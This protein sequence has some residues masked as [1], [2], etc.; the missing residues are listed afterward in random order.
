[1]RDTAQQRWFDAGE[2]QGF[3]IPNGSTEM[4]FFADDLGP[5]ELQ[6]QKVSHFLD[7]GQ[8]CKQHTMNETVHELNSG[9]TRLV[10]FRMLPP[11]AALDKAYVI[12]VYND[13]LVY[14]VQ[15]LCNDND[16]LYEVWPPMRLL[17]RPAPDCNESCANCSTTTTD[18]CNGTYANPLYRG[19]PS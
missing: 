13:T 18:T 9:T 10:N 8:H 14:I 5:D 19:N 12:R 17:Q 6:C 7:C 15:G 11:G 1:M 2:A 4:C 3:L 16:S